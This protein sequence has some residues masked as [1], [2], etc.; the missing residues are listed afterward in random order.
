MSHVEGVHQ[1]KR[2]GYVF[3]D[4]LLVSTKKRFHVELLEY[5]CVNGN[6]DEL[7]DT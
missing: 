6:R 1:S 7:I 5:M 3:S 4:D 2:S